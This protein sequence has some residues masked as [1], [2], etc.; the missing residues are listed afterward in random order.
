M[1]AFTRGYVRAGNWW[2]SP[3]LLHWSIL[4]G[5][6]F[7]SGFRFAPAFWAGFF[8]L[9]LL[10]EL[11]HAYFVRRYGQRVLS[12]EV[13]GLGGLCTWSGKVSPIRRA[14][15]A[16]GG[17]LA[18]WLVYSGATFFV[19][20]QGVPETSG[21]REILHVATTTNLWMIALNLIPVRPLDGAEAWPLFPRL[22]RRWR[23]RHVLAKDEE[24]RVQRMLSRTKLRAA[25]ALEDEAADRPPPEIASLVDDVL[26]R[27]K[28]RDPK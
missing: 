17:V 10:H 23:M 25:D 16:W 9:V 4:L 5:A 3:L 8:G 6:L 21:G 2:G 22:Y 24:L 11:G 19:W 26:R 20:I 13:H 28:E 15:I 7:F 27:A 1:A 12:V 14:V 18:Q